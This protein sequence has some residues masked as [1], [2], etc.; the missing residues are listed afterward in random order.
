MDAVVNEAIET[1]TV[2]YNHWRIFEDYLYADIGVFDCV[3]C[4][5][6]GGGVHLCTANIDSNLAIGYCILGDLVVPCWGVP[7]NVV[8]LIIYPYCNA[9][10]NV[11]F[12]FVGP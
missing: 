12:D 9:I 2:L 11:A 6:V 7:T 8:C 4:H 5:N 1:K 10:D 3:L